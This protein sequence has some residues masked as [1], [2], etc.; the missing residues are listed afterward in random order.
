MP[1]PEQLRK[2]ADAQAKLREAEKRR[3]L[4]KIIA[5]L[6]RNQAVRAAA[7][8]NQSITKKE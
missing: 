6:E 7:M 8:N 2:L 5:T 4:D 3:R 1:T